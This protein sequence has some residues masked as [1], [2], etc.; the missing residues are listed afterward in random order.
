MVGMADMVVHM[1]EL[2][3]DN[4]QVDTSR[5]KANIIKLVDIQAKDNNKFNHNHARLRCQSIYNVHFK[6]GLSRVLRRIN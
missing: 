4:Q 1:A 3:V 5:A 2:K 6:V